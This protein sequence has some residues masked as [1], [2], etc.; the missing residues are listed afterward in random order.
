MPST[1]TLRPQRRPKTPN[2]Q[3]QKKLA[4]IDGPVGDNRQIM[5]RFHCVNAVYGIYKEHNSKKQGRKCLVTPCCLN[6]A[7]TLLGRTYYHYEVRAELIA[8]DAAQHPPY[9][10]LS[11]L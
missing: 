9:C 5:G 7:D 10:E 4:E 2:S 8:V 3:F 11:P 1:I 6:G